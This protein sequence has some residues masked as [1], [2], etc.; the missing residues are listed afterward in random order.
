MHSLLRNNFVVIEAED[1]EAARGIMFEKHGKLWA[2]CYNE[3]AF[4]GQPK[5]Y[6]LTQ[7]PLGTPNAIEH[8]YQD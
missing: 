1:S 5:R 8:E 7:V 3:D 6:G 4:K 2:F